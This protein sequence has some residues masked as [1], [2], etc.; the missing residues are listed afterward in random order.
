M[1]GQQRARQ[2]ASVPE[3]PCGL[4]AARESSCAPFAFASRPGL[5][6]HFP[7]G[8]SP[9]SPRKA[10]DGSQG[11]PYFVLSPLSGEARICVNRGKPTA[12]KP[13]LGIDG[14]LLQIPG[15]LYVCIR[16][17]SMLPRLSSSYHDSFLQNMKFHLTRHAFPDLP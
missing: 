14:M 11:G 7:Q 4:L 5:T 12:D 8:T 2:Q 1:A 17:H 16:D 15:S 10:V 6:G 9:Y 13:R 3:E